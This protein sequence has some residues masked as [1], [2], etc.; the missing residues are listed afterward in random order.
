M[1]G[2]GTGVSAIAFRLALR[3]DGSVVS[4]GGEKPADEVDVDTGPPTGTTR[5]GGAPDLPPGS[6]WPSFGD[7]PMAFVAQ[8]NLAEVAPLDERG[9][10]PPAG[11]VSFFCSPA[12]LGRE[13]SWHVSFTEAGTALVRSELPAE[14]PSHDRFGAVGLR[15]EPELTYPPP[16]PSTLER[17]GLSPHEGLA[18]EDILE[19]ESDSPRH[20]MLGHPD[21]VQSDMREAGPDL[22]LVLQIDSDDAAGMMWGDMGRLYFW[23][24]PEDL[25]ACRFDRSRLDYQSS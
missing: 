23:I 10:L 16:D 4:W 24:R 21:I 22:C 15:A 6:S 14:I 9:L 5:L 7:R 11:L 18:Y 19:D 3:S 8:V 1:A 12:D 2:L 13:G 25:V 17:L 20:R